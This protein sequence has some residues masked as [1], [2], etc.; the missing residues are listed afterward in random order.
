M[1]GTYKVPIDPDDASAQAERDQELKDTGTVP[2]DVFRESPEQADVVAESSAECVLPEDVKELI[3][4]LREAEKRAEAEHD[5]TLRTL[6]EFN[7]FRRRTREEMDQ[8][9]KFAI[10][11]L[12]IRILP[13]L[14]NFERAIATA[15][16]LC[17]YEAL[18]GG[19][20]LILRQFRDILE[21]EGVKPIEAEGLEFDPNLHEAVMREDTDA[22]P[23]NTVIEE[24]QKGYTL[25]DKVV[26][27]SMVKVAKQP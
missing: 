13:I 19:V 1:A 18:H 6:A 21:K 3:E 2:E 25:G 20:I 12:V 9:R 15:E 7:N 10:E 16:E 23:D 5:Q 27:P 24:F 14:D 11:D 26:R 4:R 22:Y 17:D 8:A